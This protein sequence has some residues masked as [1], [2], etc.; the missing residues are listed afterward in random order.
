L[1]RVLKRSVVA[2]TAK[3]SFQS[4][5]LDDHARRTAFDQKVGDRIDIG[6][7]GADRKM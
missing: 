5:A 3:I 1:N 2:G 4:V 7:A 6:G